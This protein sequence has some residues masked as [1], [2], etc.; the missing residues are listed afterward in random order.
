MKSQPFLIN[1][2]FTHRLEYFLIK[3]EQGAIACDVKTYLILWCNIK[4]CNPQQNI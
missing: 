1:F 3:L 4:I 2:C